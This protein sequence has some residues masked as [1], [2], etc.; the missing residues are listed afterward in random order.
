MITPQELVSQDLADKWAL[1]AQKYAGHFYGYKIR[2]QQ[3]GKGAPDVELSEELWEEPLVFEDKCEFCAVMTDERVE[4]RILGF[5]AAID[6]EVLGL[7]YGHYRPWIESDDPRVPEPR[8]YDS[9]RN[10]R[11]FIELFQDMPTPNRPEGWK[12]RA[13]DLT[14]LPMHLKRR[15]CIEWNH[16]F[17]EWLDT[18]KDAF[19]YDFEERVVRAKQN[20]EGIAVLAVDPVENEAMTADLEADHG[21]AA[22]DAPTEAAPL[23]E[24][25]AEEYEQGL[26]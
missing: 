2:A 8:Q 21:F 7:K 16:I 17:R 5:Q 18:N 11:L 22:T 25:I 3:H 4:D 12:N 14:K 24:Q 1:A 20:P 15:L 10:R 26:F 9:R 6:K 23:D 13:L 19:Y